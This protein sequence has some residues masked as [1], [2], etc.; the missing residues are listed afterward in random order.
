MENLRNTQTG[1]E[2]QVHVHVFNVFFFASQMTICVR[3]VSRF[4]KIVFFLPVS[5]PFY[6]CY[7]PDI[8]NSSLLSNVRCSV[9]VKILSKLQ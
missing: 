8:S 5:L 4:V 3:T 6:N 1:R 2:V 7:N 9:P